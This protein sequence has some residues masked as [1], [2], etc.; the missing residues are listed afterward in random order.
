MPHMSQYVFRERSSFRPNLAGL[1][2]PYLKRKKF[3]TFSMATFRHNKQAL[4]GIFQYVL[5]STITNPTHIPSLS[6]KKTLQNCYTKS[7]KR[8]NTKTAC[9]S[10]PVMT[11]FRFFRGSVKITDIRAFFKL[12]PDT[13]FNTEI[14][15]MSGKL[16]TYGNPKLGVPC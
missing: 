14:P 10:L 7:Y 5:T 4:Y 6:K 13:T 3:L 11:I 1:G 12:F 16:R 8:Q 15:D 9:F 2:L